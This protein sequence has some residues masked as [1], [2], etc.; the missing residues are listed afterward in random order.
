MSMIIVMPC[1]V[2]FLFSTGIDLKYVFILNFDLM[3]FII[4]II[5]AVF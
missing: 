2:N 4:I 3:T 1:I 5:C